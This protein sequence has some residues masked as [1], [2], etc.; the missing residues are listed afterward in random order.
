MCILLDEM[1][2]RENLVY[3]KSTGKLVGYTAHLL[4]FEKSLSEKRNQ[5][6]EIA[7]TM[8]VIIWSAGCFLNSDFRMHNFLA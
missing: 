4:A 3:T 5:D 6:E 1:Y 8:L 2:I 7:K